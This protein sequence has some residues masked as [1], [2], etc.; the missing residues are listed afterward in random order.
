MCAHCIAP[1]PPGRSADQGL[2]AG[3]LQDAG[4]RVGGN[5]VAQHRAKRRV[6]AGLPPDTAGLALRRRLSWLSVLCSCPACAA[7]AKTPG[8]PSSGA[9]I[10]PRAAKINAPPPR[11]AVGRPGACTAWSPAAL[12]PRARPGDRRR[13]GDH[14]GP[15][16][17]RLPE[18]TPCASAYASFAPLGVGRRRAAGPRPCSGFGPTALKIRAR[19]ARR[20]AAPCASLPRS[21]ARE[22]RPSTTFRAAI[23]RRVEH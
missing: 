5:P 8:T 16:I 7:C 11:R 23:L 20:A 10:R 12:E 2:R 22:P 15:R 18:W 3:R 21:S 19:I 1:C 14:I 6:R 9:G 13:S 17:L 4:A